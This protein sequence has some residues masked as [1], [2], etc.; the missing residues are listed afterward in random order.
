MQIF[1]V[2]NSAS[3]SPNGVRIK[4]AAKLIKASTTEVA[5]L[6]GRD[7]TRLLGSPLPYLAAI[8]PAL[9]GDHFNN[10]DNAARIE[11]AGKG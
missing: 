5:I 2:R 6:D 7:R 11:Y 1:S 9:E 8:P 10:G 3:L 4:K